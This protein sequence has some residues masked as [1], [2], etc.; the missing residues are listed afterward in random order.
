M[1]GQT[2]IYFDARWIGPTGIGRFATVLE[3]SLKLI[4]LD[5]SGSPVSISD[6]IRFLCAILLKTKP[7]SLVFSPGFNA[8]LWIPRDF[9]FCIMDLNHI[10]RP[11]N[12]NALK[13]IYYRLIIRSAVRKSVATLTISEYFRERIANWA[14]VHPSK[15]VNVSCGVEDRFTPDAIPRSDLGKYFLCVSNRKKHKNEFRIIEGFANADLHPDVK[16]VFTGKITSELF[17]HCRRYH[18]DSRVIF[19]GH[20]L[21]D[22]LPSLY[23][24]AIALI[25]P[26][27]YEGFGLPAV[28]AMACGTPVLTSNTTALPEVT[29]D[30]AL[31]V[32]PT[33]VDE[34]SEGISRLWADE[35]LRL[36][37][38][39]KGIE[40]AK[41]FRWDDVVS[42]VKS[43]LQPDL[44]TT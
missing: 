1:C 29:G 42:K 37:L 35:W 23:T 43:A 26:S 39:N 2:K 14:S 11:E 25:F 20:V 12:S 19:I 16:L 41:K 38:R 40:R 10:D 28:E 21:E 5:M 9:I 24:G 33:S 15:I 3:K 22:D 17:G 31:L 34:I 27:L 6:P 4:P 36:D 18:L 32:D 30:A 8:P 44:G 13:R 7:G